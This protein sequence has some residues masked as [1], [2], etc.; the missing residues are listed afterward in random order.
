MATWSFDVNTIYTNMSGYFS[1]KT[2]PQSAC[3]EHTAKVCLELSQNYKSPLLQATGP[4][5]Q[6]TQY[7]AGPYPYSFFE[8]TADAGLEIN[9]FDSFFIYYNLPPS[10]NPNEEGNAGFELTFKT[11]DVLE[12]LL[13]QPG[14]P[15]YWSR[16]G[17][18]IWFAMA[19]NAQF[20]AYLRYQ[21]EHPFPNRGTASAG[22]DP[23]LFENT[24]QDIIEIGTA[25]RLAQFN[26]NMRQ[27]ATDF[28][29]VIKGML[30][31]TTETAPGFIFGRTSQEQRDQQTTTKQM[32]L[33]MR[34]V[35]R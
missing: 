32:R 31:G 6:L 4:V 18:Q 9:K 1:G 5:Q 29:Q 16:H 2:I 26:F 17:D 27:R 10:L 23:I 20:Y 14:V 7:K 25:Q 33:K 24:W 30:T 11:I 22:S 15:S 12:I 35:M 13:N 21:K 28:A 3:W 34:P 19:P 8:N